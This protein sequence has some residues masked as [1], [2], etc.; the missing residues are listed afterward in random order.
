MLALFLV[1]P[2]AALLR[3]LPSANLKHSF[4]LLVGVALMMWIFDADWIHPFLSML[5][6][7]VLC[8]SGRRGRCRQ[9]RGSIV[10]HLLL[11]LS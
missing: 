4:S 8:F 2:L 10:M 7:Y 9:C 6:T 5:G 11:V 3:M 1:Y